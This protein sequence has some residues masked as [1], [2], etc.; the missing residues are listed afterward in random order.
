MDRRPTGKVRGGR[1]SNVLNDHKMLSQMTLKRLKTKV[2]L[3]SM[4]EQ[5]FSLPV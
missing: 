1:D 4:K 2:N 3:G 5:G